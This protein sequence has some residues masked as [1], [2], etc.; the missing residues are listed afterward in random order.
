MIAAPLISRLF[1]Y[2]A[3]GAV[4][5]GAAMPHHAAAA[6]FSLQGKSVT[7]HTQCPLVPSNGQRP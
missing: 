3:V 1:I 4:V 7:H 6:P 5:A 2:T